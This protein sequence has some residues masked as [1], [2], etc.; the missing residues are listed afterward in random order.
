MRSATR[1]DGTDLAKG[2]GIS[3][4]VSQAR[5]S[6]RPIGEGDAARCDD[7]GGAA[8]V[9]AGGQPAAPLLRRRTISDGKHL[10][11]ILDGGGAAAAAGP[12]MV[13]VGR[14]VVKR[15]VVLAWW[16]ARLRRPRGDDRGHRGA[17]MDD[18]EGPSTMGGGGRPHRR[19][20]GH[21]VA[22]AVV[23]AHQVAPA[24]QVA[25]IVV[26]VVARRGPRPG[27]GT[28][29]TGGKDGG[30]RGEGGGGKFQPRKNPG[31][32]HLSAVGGGAGR[33][34]DLRATGGQWIPKG[35]PAG[36][37][38]KG[39]T[40]MEAATETRLHGGVAR[41][42]GSPHPLAIEIYIVGKG[43][44][45]GG[46]T[47]FARLGDITVVAFFAV[48]ER[49]KRAPASAEEIPTPLRAILSTA[50]TPIA[51]AVAAATPR[52][53]EITPVFCERG[54]ATTRLQGGASVNLHSTPR[55][56]AGLSPAIRL[57]GS[58]GGMVST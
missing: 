25:S 50:E 9:S 13:V 55:L 3:R 45:R 58:R 47:R 8:V 52:A 28:G 24:A 7:V 37:L 23:V 32:P 17:M 43:T 21:V 56:G 31:Q 5:R 16:A 42:R 38:R 33:G 40:P 44:S 22:A 36:P 39:R 41:D 46:G 51:A 14:R 30:R 57:R 53:G 29:A 35:D 15:G 12:P 19:R 18:E 27:P 54:I 6:S 34:V 11:L 48:E 10:L 1:C 26:V 49:E 20:G 4:Q 2:W